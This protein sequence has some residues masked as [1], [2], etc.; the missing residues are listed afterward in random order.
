MLPALRQCQRV[1]LVLGLVSVLTVCSTPSP[2]PIPTAS[3]D[4]TPRPAVVVPTSTP[5]PRP[6]PRP[7]AIPIAVCPTKA[8]LAYFKEVI[9]YFHVTSKSALA[10]GD[11]LMQASRDISVTETLDWQVTI[12]VHFTLLKEAADTI[13]DATAPLSVRS[14]SEPVEMSA[15]LLKYGINNF[16]LG[17]ANSDIDALEAGTIAFE[18]A[19][20]ESR[21]AGEAATTFC[22]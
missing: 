15:R 9:K 1:A 21:K 4:P 20:S 18:Q 8:E 17:G 16:L 22:E 3:P 11:L 12:A 14:I 6:T 19:T 10:T 2:T 13:L 5:A 7:T